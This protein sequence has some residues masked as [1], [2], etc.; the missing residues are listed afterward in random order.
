M[1][2]LIHAWLLAPRGLGVPPPPQLRLLCYD[3]EQDDIALSTELEVP[4]EKS[5]ALPFSPYVT[6][7]LPI[8]PDSS[9]KFDN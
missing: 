4:K 1:L 8:S 3:R 6:P 5:L 9:S 2:Q 7:I